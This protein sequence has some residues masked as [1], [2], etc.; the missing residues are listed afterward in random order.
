MYISTH[1]SLVPFFPSLS[2]SKN[3]AYYGVLC[4]QIPPKLAWLF[5]PFVAHYLSS[6][7]IAFP[8]LAIVSVL[9]HMALNIEAIGNFLGKPNSLLWAHSLLY[10]SAVSFMHSILI[11]AHK[12]ICFPITDGPFMH[13]CG[14][15]KASFCCNSKPL[16]RAFP[17]K[18]CVPFSL[19]LKRP[20][21]NYPHLNEGFFEWAAKKGLSCLSRRSLEILLSLFYATFRNANS[22]PS[23]HGY[24]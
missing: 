2:L 7:C 14:R 17:S 12:T 18:A 21:Q 10:L 15:V 16:P 8:L 19:L 20:T 22:L 23:W 13:S 5:S 9:V 6:W 4:G 24:Q 3:K 1:A 11:A